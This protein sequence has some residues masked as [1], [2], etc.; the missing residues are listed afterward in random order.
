MSNETKASLSWW[1]DLVFKVGTPL[2]LA[3]LFYLKSSFATHDEVANVADRVGKVE[4]ALRV[5]V[6]Q[7]RVN[8]RQDESICDHEQRLRS[9]ERAP[10]TP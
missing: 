1:I 10:R 4:T 8:D 5:M 2:G 3:A 9:L 6:E 7:N